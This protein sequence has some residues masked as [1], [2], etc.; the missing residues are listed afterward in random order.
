MRNPPP[1]PTRDPVIPA[2]VPIKK[3]FRGTRCVRVD[4]GVGCGV[5]VELSDLLRPG[6]EDPW[7]LFD[8]L[9]RNG[10]SRSL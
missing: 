4:C 6:F 8:M 10:K 7:L 9:S 1:N 5:G 3:D 2:N